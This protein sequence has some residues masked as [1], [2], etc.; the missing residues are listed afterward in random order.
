[1]IKP[2]TVVAPDLVVFSSAFSLVRR[3]TCGRWLDCVLLILGVVGLLK[4][5]LV[6]PSV[7]VPSV[8][9]GGTIELLSQKGQFFLERFIFLVIFFAVFI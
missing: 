7:R 3:Q 2:L 9:F 8:V 1:M 4:A 5:L 6:W